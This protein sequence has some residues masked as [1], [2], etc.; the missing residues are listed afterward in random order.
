MGARGS[1]ICDWV[2]DKG[3]MFVLGGERCPLPVVGI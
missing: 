3:W 2:E 1:K